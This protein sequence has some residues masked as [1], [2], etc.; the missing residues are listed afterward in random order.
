[1][2]VFRNIYS[3]PADRPKHMAVSVN[4]WKYKLI[5]KGYFGG[6]TALSK[7]QFETINGFSNSF[8]GWG[9]EDDD[10]YHRVVEKGYKMFRYPGNIARYSMLKHKNVSSHFTPDAAYANV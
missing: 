1:M 8:Y 10:L 2:Y 5:Y 4:K 7:D 6:V 9:G 3:C